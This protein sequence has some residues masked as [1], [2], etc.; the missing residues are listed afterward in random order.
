MRREPPQAV[1]DVSPTR[2]GRLSP[3]DRTPLLTALLAS[4]DLPHDGE[5]AV[6]EWVHLL[7]A[8]DLIRT[9]D[10]RGP[11]RIENAAAIIAASFAQADACD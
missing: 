6:P 9:G 5:H 7:P 3:H 10:D 2:H 1:A 4:Q 11:Y 8:G